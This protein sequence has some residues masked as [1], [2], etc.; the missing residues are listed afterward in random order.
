MF[1]FNF[2]KFNNE[3]LKGQYSQY[4]IISVFFLFLITGFTIVKDYGIS[5]DE[6]FQRSIGYF[7]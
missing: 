7:Y 2:N 6:P 1:K 4:L 5:T 3:I